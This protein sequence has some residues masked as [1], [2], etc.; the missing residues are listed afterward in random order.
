MNLR[1][2]IQKEALKVAKAINDSKPK[3]TSATDHLIIKDPTSKR[4]YRVERY[5]NQGQVKSSNFR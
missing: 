3:F 4:T 2:E 1:S 5:K